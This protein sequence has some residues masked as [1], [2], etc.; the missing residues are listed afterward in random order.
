MC[1]PLPTTNRGV[2]RYV[3]A[4]VQYRPAIE[5]VAL[6]AH[7]HGVCVALS[8]VGASTGVTQEGG[9]IRQDLFFSCP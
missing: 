5:N 8:Y 7:V 3:H 9:L 6:T 4:P 2:Y 1:S